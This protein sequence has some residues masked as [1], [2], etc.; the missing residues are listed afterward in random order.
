MYVFIIH[1]IERGPFRLRLPI[2]RV[3]ERASV[4]VGVFRLC[5]YMFRYNIVRVYAYT[6]SMAGE[7]KR[8]VVV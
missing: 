6:F 2:T 3:S 8:V 1:A 4:S 5:V 7:P